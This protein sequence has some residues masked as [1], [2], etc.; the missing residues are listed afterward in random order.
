[1]KILGISAHFHES[2]AC[3]LADG[4]L[5][6]AAEEER[7]SRVKHD[8]AL[9]VSAVRFCLDAGGIDVHDL[10]CVAYYERPEAKLAR[11]LW[12]GRL[13]ARPIGLDPMRPLREIREALGYDGRVETFDHHLSH[14]G[15]SFLYS[16]LEEAAILTVD[17]VGEWT[18]TAYG[19]GK[20]EAIELFETVEFPHSLGLLYSTLTSYLGFRVNGG[21]YKVMGLA[22]YGRPR[23]LS[24]IRK[25]VRSEEGGGYELALEYFD[26][27]KGRRMYS[28]KLSELLGEPPRTPESEV[29]SFHRDLARSLQQ[30]LE[31]ILLEKVSYL[32]R[33][34]PSENLCLGGGVALNCVANGRILREGPFARL[35]VQPAAGDSGS[36]L[37]AAALAHVRLTG[38]RHGAA[39]LEHVYLGPRFASAS[40][41]ET[42]SAA[43]V[44][45]LD[46]RG[47]EAELLEAVV[48]RLCRGGVVGWF[49]GPMELGP[50][51][52]GARSILAD[53]RRPEMRERLN[54]LV[55]KREAFRPFAPS[56]L[57]SEAS[58]HLELD[59]PSPFMLET[60]QVRS[61]LE[62]P[63][64][65][66]VDGSARPQ[67][68]DP[69][70][71][72]RYARL[73]GAFQKRTGCPL[74]VNTSFNVR[75]E[76]IVCTPED[77][78]SCAV[79]ADLDALAIE[80]FLVDRSGFPPELVELVRQRD[81]WAARQSSIHA[82]LYTFI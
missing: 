18:T 51:A 80:D 31:E 11:Q 79:R 6:A 7:F 49:Q 22:P 70:H 36:C 10:D 1:M 50:R 59:H 68:V 48:D 17:G 13:P 56:I 54:A 37:G 69:R 19:R 74:L 16:G 29:S 47:R 32:H 33:K 64:V 63:A 41:G 4:R 23:F 40:V 55:K 15:A 2:A 21:E 30:V 60:C 9:P 3:L 72:P 8:A 25:L 44:K 39:P 81:R 46:Y 27:V 58:G 52:L 62:L 45:A 75:D 78:I 53:P 57:Q 82:A 43:G 24:E 35:F 26:F 20:G 42:L 28:D 73:L 66:H 38:R 76:P 5:V 12:S 65:T 67:T 14:A 77:A 34:A 71:A 61:P